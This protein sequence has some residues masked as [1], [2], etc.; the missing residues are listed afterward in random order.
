K[1]AD[2]VTVLIRSR[3]LA[4]GMSRYLVDRIEAAPNIDV[5]T[6]TEL[7]A[8]HGEE[9]LESISLTRRGELTDERP[10]ADGVFIFIGAVPHTENLRDT[11][12]TDDRGF[13][14]TGADLGEH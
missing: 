8:A 9:R 7:G 1:Y 11:L 3:S 10:P 13:L 5:L 4:K 2:R 14:L 12:P 6:Y